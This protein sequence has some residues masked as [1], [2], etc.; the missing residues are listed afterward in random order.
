MSKSPEEIKDAV[1]KC[2]ETVTRMHDLEIVEYFPQ[3]GIQLDSLHGAW[4]FCERHPN[5]GWHVTFSIYPELLETG[6]NYL[7]HPDWIKAYRLLNLEAKELQEQFEE[8]K[9]YRFKTMEEPAFQVMGDFAKFLNEAVEADCPMITNWGVK[10][11][12]TGEDI[13][14]LN[15]WAATTHDSPITRC[16]ELRREIDS[17][18]ERAQGLVDALEKIMRMIEIQHA[19]EFGQAIR[20]ES[21][22]VEEKP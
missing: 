8:A 21:Q 4:R 18:Q 1:L 16:K 7:H 2:C 11:Q 5:L 20:K 17:L 10:I 9:I 14:I 6:I 19:D 15:I 13:S 22:P 12:E 3:L